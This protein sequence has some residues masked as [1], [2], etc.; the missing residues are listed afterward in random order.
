MS[1]EVKLWEEQTEERSDVVAVVASCC[2]CCCCLSDNGCQ[3]T[4]NFGCYYNPYI[5]KKNTFSLLQGLNQTHYIYS[6]IKWC[7]EIM[8]KITIL[9]F[10]DFFPWAKVN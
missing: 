8:L 9:H 1:D 5:P 10:T 4:A 6:N 7:C 2:C 3:M